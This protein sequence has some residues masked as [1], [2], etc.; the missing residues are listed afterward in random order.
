MAIKRH[1][2]E[3]LIS[4][5]VGEVSR[6]LPDDFLLNHSLRE[7][8]RNMTVEQSIQWLKDA[9]KI[10]KALADKIFNRKNENS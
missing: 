9:E 7:Q 8:H 10:N 2:P 1:I 4:E 5:L 3:Q 6:I